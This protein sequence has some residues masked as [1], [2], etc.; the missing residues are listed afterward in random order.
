MGTRPTHQQV[1]VYHF[2]NCVNHVRVLSIMLLC[3]GAME[4]GRFIGVCHLL[5]ELPQSY[6]I[7][8]FVQGPLCEPE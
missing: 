1:T 2:V 5:A 3:R 7:L 4:N 8:A 6:F